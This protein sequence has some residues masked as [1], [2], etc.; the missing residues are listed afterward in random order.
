MQKTYW[1]ILK[2]FLNDKKIPRVP[3]LFHDDKFVTNFKEKAELC[4]FFF[5]EA[6]VY[7]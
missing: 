3:H 1:S 2:R 4:K 5:S 7:N 6:M